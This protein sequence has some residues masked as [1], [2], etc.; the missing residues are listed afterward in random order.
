MNKDLVK[1][2]NYVNI[3]LIEKQ[4]TSRKPPFDE[5][6]S[7]HVTFVI[8]AKDQTEH[9]YDGSRRTAFSSRRKTS[10]WS[11]HRLATS[12]GSPFDKILG[13]KF[14]FQVAVVVICLSVSEGQY[15]HIFRQGSWTKT[16]Q[17]S[18]SHKLEMKIL[19]TDCVHLF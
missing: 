17:F 7:N 14:I 12:S 13:G 5:P 16:V 2:L 10:R 1:K 3:S 18:L 4:K 8:D 15:E 11:S 6:V 9:I 19:L